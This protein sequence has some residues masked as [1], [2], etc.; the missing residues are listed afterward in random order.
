[1][2]LFA[3][4]VRCQDCN[5]VWDSLI[6]RSERDS[7]WPCPECGG[8]GKRAVSAPM[9]MTASYPEGT[10]RKGWADLKEASKLKIESAN[11]RDDKKREIAK[12]IRKMGVK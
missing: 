7:Q 8:M 1:M 2:S 3:I 9:V 5:H 11:S 6:Q 10:K 12:E 4:D